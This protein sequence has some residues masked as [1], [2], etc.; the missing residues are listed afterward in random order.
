VSDSQQDWS[1]RRRL[2]R[3]MIAASLATLLAGGAAVY[4]AAEHEDG[5]LLDARLHDLARTILAFSAHELSEI[6]AD[7]RAERLHVETAATLDSRYRYQIWSRSG[8]LLLYSYRSHAVQPL[9][10]LDASGFLD[11]TFEGE[12]LRVYALRDASGQMTI[13]VAECLDDRESAIG[14]VGPYFLIFLL[15]PFLVIVLLT[16]WMLRDS[17][18]ALVSSATEL[19]RRGP[20]DLAPL[21]AD[22][23]PQELKPMIG[24]INLLFE[25]VGR[26]MSIE[27]RFTATAAHELRTPLAGL[28]A[29]AQLATT[30]RSPEELNES[31][32]SVMCA[33]D[34]A[35]HLLDQLLDLARVEGSVGG[36]AEHRTWVDLS[37]VYT[38][39]LGDL[40]DA[41]SGRAMRL[42][43][44]FAV[45]EIQATEV[46]L[47]LV[48]RN[49]LSNAMRHTPEGGEI[50]ISSASEADHIA[51]TVDDSGPGIP[52]HLRHRVFER[53]DRLGRAEG[54]G[55]GLGMSIVHA[56]VA[57]HGALVHLLESPLGGLRVQVRFP[58]VAGAAGP[59]VPG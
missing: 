23:P 15:V 59:A 58:L 47:A 13:Q 12:H 3:L 41:C 1:L 32:Q 4:W 34:R 51:L 42:R 46:G 19:T 17:L 48:M 10:P 54:D 7:G 27:R 8:E 39:V 30:A 9:V 2:L 26:A 6:A 14:I 50:Q 44:D 49:L 24:A 25:R 45:P 55:V 35:A 52:E 53:F 33:V 40:G 43:A 57:A 37:Q 5:K 18:R 28:R 31:L 29:Q 36:A 16:W 11:A 38:S 21:H 22:N 56:V 20:Q